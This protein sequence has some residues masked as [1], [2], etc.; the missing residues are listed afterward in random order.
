MMN[1][2]TL[3]ELSVKSLKEGRTRELDPFL[4]IFLIESSFAC[5]ILEPILKA[6]CNFWNLLFPPL[7]LRNKLKT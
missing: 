5:H 2:G 3:I 1:I 6:T 7:K 4:R